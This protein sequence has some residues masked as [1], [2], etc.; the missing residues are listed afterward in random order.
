MIAA[1]GEQPSPYAFAP[2]PQLEGRAEHAEGLLGHESHSP[3]R[4][5]RPPHLPIHAAREPVERRRLA[6]V[7]GDEVAGKVEALQDHPGDVTLRLVRPPRPFDLTKEPRKRLVSSEHKVR[8]DGTPGVS[9]VPTIDP[10][11]GQAPRESPDRLDRT[12]SP[13]QRL[14]QRRQ[15]QGDGEHQDGLTPRQADG[16]Q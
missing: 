15:E 4:V 11:S 2:R 16:Y 6:P 14:N 8:A 12:N 7:L 3:G 9:G 13:S 1:L 5:K 10:L